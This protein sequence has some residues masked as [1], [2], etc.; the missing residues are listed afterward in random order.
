MELN[1]SFIL[2]SNLFRE[3]IYSQIGKGKRA[4]SQS[5]LVTFLLYFLLIFFTFP[6]E[7]IYSGAEEGKSA[8]CRSNLINGR[9][10]SLRA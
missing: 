9:G 4:V 3:R 6:R 10:K 8:V 5:I 7:T 2:I 1:H